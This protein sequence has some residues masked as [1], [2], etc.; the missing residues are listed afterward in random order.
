MEHADKNTPALVDRRV[1]PQR[2]RGLS[3]DFV[4]LGRDPD[5][6]AG[7]VLPVGEC[8]SGCRRGAVA[9]VRPDQRRRLNAILP[10]I[11]ELAA[12]AVQMQFVRFFD[13]GGHRE[14]KPFAMPSKGAKLAQDALDESLPAA[15]GFAGNVDLGD[16]G[17]VVRGQALRRVRAREAQG[18]Q[19]LKPEGERMAAT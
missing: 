9:M 19:T 1:C 4:L 17:Q 2:R 15:V 10:G 12:G 16:T 6:R 11:Q 7:I 5:L 13:A 3:I 8:A 18:R 14:F